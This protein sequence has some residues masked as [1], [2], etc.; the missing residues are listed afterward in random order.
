MSDLIVVIDSS[1]ILEGKLEDLK[2]AMK[3]L[4]EFVQKNEPRPVA[5]AVYLDEGGATVTVLQIHPDS[6]STEF[7]MN[8]A[9]SEFSKFTD[10]VRLKS[11]DVYGTPSEDLLEKLRTKG[12]LLGSTTLVVHELH[13]GFSRFGA[14]DRGLETGLTHHG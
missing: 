13:A 1:E 4:V 14:S 10:L 12:Q 9:A 3:E 7:H 11:M 5:Y 6:A 8:V 2:T